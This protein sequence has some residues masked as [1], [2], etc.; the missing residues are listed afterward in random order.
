[1]QV[2]AGQRLKGKVTGIK[3]FG[4]FVQLENGQ[5]GLVHISELSDKFVDS[6]EDVVSIGQEVE[7]RVKEVS[8]EGKLNFSM[9]S[10]EAPPRKPVRSLDLDKAITSFLKDSDEKQSTLKKAAK[11][12]KRRS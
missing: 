8:G 12:S 6:V 5:S 11:T 3:P 1:M 9:K 7:V 10:G 2:T 4:A